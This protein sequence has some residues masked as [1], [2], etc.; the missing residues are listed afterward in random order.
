M[1]WGSPAPKTSELASPLPS[2]FLHHSFGSITREERRSAPLNEAP[3]CGIAGIISKEPF[4]PE[5]RSAMVSCM[6]QALRHRG[7]D[8]QGCWTDAA[9]RAAL[10]HCRL[11]IIDL[12]PEGHQPRVSHDGR[13]VMVFNGEIYNYL[14]LR[15]ELA[16]SGVP[17]HGHSDTEVLLEA[18][19]SWGV[20]V[21]LP[22]LVGMF[23]FA[24]WDESDQA[25]ILARDRAGKKP[26]Y[27]VSQPGRFYFSSELKALRAL[28][29]GLSLDGEAVYQYLTFGFVPSP[30]TIYREAGEVL[31]GHW[32]RLDAQKGLT[33][34]PYW[35]LSWDRKRQVSFSEAVEE[36]DYLLKDA[37]RLRLR[38]D[39]PVGCFLSGGIDSGL[40]TAMASLELNRPL[41]T[42][43]VAFSEGPFDETGLAR[44]VAD[45]YGTK[46]HVI[47]LSPDLNEVL[48]H[49]VKT[50]DQPLADASIIPSY[51][52]SQEARKFVKVV[53]NG[54]G[55]DE[56]FGG[57]RRQMA[58]KW[59]TQAQGL[60]DLMPDLG[61]HAVSR[62]LPPP[63]TQRSRYAFLHRFIRGLGHDPFHR[64]I[65]W[66]VDGFLEEE[67]ASLYRSSLPPQT[68]SLKVLKEQFGHLAHL[69]PL[70]FSMAL[71]FLFQM[72]NDMLVKMDLATMAHGLEGR[73]PFLDHHLVEWSAALPPGIRHKGLGSKPLLRALARRY[74][75]PEVASVPKRGFE[76]PLVTWLR[77]D[78]FD[79][80]HDACL[81]GNGLIREL[82][83][84]SSLESLLFER[85][86]LD[87]DRWSRR[88][89][90]LFMLALWGEAYT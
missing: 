41:K 89:F 30:R 51:C 85:R 32:M 15:Q 64:Y 31:A 78:L 3:M 8:D 33:A 18:I 1:P 29:I 39:V 79:M 58:V 88:V 66:S 7:P 23:A 77:R 76:I 60:L 42:F 26:L 82:F 59:F 53:L 87:P 55:G 34:Q 86:P 46:H 48:P 47:Q 57:Y 49:L 90:T 25:L 22:R 62:W 44:Q 28:P 13:Y 20:E 10:G 43:T 4:N 67:K 11:A 54:E 56:L 61:W 75:P 37:V 68:A 83:D 74:L 50:Y 71:D 5:D 73:N 2:V 16:R 65:V 19:A 24:V 52:I 72:E 70:D 14:E 45:R 81:A 6:V 9:G 12:T 27:Y 40:L 84:R 69:D 21:T 63:K 38:A 36:A 80:V 17:F 35:Q